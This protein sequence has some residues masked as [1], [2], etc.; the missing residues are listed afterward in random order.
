MSRP[1]IDAFKARPIYKVEIKQAYE[2][3]FEMFAEAFGM[4]LGLMVLP[5]DFVQY[6]PDYTG[7]AKV[8]PGAP[9]TC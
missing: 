7:L 6:Y 5:K 9:W 1:I 3:T 8:M 4:P 2:I